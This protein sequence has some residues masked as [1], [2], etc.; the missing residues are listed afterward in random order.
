[1]HE[2]DAQ[3]WNILAVCYAFSPPFCGPLSDRHE[4]RER[5]NLWLGLEVVYHQTWG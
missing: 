1:M 5:E 2:Y 4:P 3:R